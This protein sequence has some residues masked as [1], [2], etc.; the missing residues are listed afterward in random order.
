MVERERELKLGAEEK[1]VALEKWVSLD[2]VVVASLRKEQ[3]ELLQTVESLC[4]ERGV[5]CEE[6]DKVLRE[7]D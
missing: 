6:H 2:V 3:D 7:H 4:S 5:A 1:L